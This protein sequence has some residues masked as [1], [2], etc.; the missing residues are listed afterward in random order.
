MV[1]PY[2][3]KKTVAS[4]QVNA[5][6]KKLF[7]VVYG[8]QT[9]AEDKRDI[10]R[11]KVSEMISK[12]SFYYEKIRN[13]VDYNEEYLLRK[14][15]IERIL[16]RQIVIEGTIKSFKTEE[17]SENLLVELIRA[18]Y[19]PNNQI[20]ETKIADTAE[21][22]EK[23]IKLRNFLYAYLRPGVHLKTGEV[24]RARD[25]LAE[26]N[27]LL[28][29][30]IALAASEIEDSLGRNKVTQMVVSN[31]YDSLIKDIKLP[32]DLPYEEDLNIQIYLAIH[33]VYLKF[34]NDMLGLILFKY[35]NGSWKNPTDEDIAYIARDII[36]LSRMINRQLG[37]PLKKE[38]EAIVKKYNVYFSILIDLIKKGPV[39]AYNSIKTDSKALAFLVKH[40]CAARY[41][42]I[43]KKLWRVAARSVIYLFLTKSIFVILLEI[44]TIKFFHEPINYFALV[45]NVT[46]PALL[47]FA[48]VLFTRMPGSKNTD[49]IIEGVSEITLEENAR[50]EPFVLRRRTK[51]GGVI[52][53]IFN[54]LYFITFF[55]SF[56]AVVWGLEKIGFTW[57]SIIIFLFFL[58]LVS[59]FGIKIKDKSRELMV[60]EPKENIFTFVMDFFYI[61][62]IA[63]GKWL[64][65]KFSRINVFAIVLD[66]VVEAPFKI[67]VETAEE[68]TKYVRERKDDIR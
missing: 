37:H 41:K 30:L 64:S 19:L 53:S 44:P 65:E 34:D 62:V 11:I 2:L 18:G 17:V 57:V 29:W 39:D 67:F 46:F 49:K 14:S 52:N 43:N 15:A 28:S 24:M 23:Y 10:P 4:S 40:A 61:P 26:R 45:I 56:G 33:R 59:Y 6:A 68:W 47:L 66:F 25:L 9:K 42:E 38:L 50:K 16:R 48:I 12:L 55:C 54:F 60:I 20:P 32:S 21:I 13:T 51:R 58:A 7:Q 5:Q 63:V 27:G 1:S 8:E 35:Y 36:P 31:M 22:I 3:S